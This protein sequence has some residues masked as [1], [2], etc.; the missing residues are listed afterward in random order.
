MYATRIAKPTTAMNVSLQAKRR[1]VIGR[2]L[3]DARDV[4]PTA[5]L[6]KPSDRG[7]DRDGRQDDERAFGGRSIP[8]AAERQRDRE[9]DD[10]R[11]HQQREH[12][13]SPSAADDHTS[14]DRQRADHVEAE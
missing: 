14:G 5:A 12:G 2:R 1:V 6:T 13:Y 8:V 9:Q 10:D 4:A 7:V 11:R 3:I